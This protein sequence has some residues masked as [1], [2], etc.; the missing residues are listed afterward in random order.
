M[1]VHWDGEKGLGHGEYPGGGSTTRSMSLLSPQLPPAQ[2]WPTAGVQGVCA[3][4]MD[5]FECKNARKRGEREG[6]GT[7][8][9]SSGRNL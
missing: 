6:G 8:C 7:F 9:M 2:A 3:G 5:V 4:H 1:M